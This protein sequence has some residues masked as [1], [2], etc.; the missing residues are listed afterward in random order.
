MFLR[1]DF[2]TIGR[3]QKRGIAARRT[4]EK[5]AQAL[6]CTPRNTANASSGSGAKYRPAMHSPE[7]AKYLNHI[8]AL[9]SSCRSSRN[10][11]RVVGRAANG[12]PQIRRVVTSSSDPAR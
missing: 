9:L 2:S 6:E 8:L 5:A 1:P 4:V 7:T 3:H 10:P 12:C 11:D